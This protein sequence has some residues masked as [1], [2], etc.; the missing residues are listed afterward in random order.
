MLRQARRQVVQQVNSLMLR[1]YFEIG[2]KIVE[3]EQSGHEQAVYGTFLIGKLT[4]SLTAAFGKGF[5][6]RN[7][8]LIRKFYLT[9]LCEITDF[10]KIPSSPYP[11][12]TIRFLPSLPD[13]FAK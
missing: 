1:T 8:E 13:H 4:K 5:S 12:A 6:K 10:A 9:Y 3:Q 7:L 11:K 2:R